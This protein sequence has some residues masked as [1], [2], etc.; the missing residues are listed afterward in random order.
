M[1]ADAGRFVRS[2]SERGLAGKNGRL[3]RV[4]RQVAR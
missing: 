4:L 2:V 3:L 1:A